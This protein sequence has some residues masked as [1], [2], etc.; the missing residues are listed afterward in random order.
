[1]GG[2]AMG[3]AVS[4]GPSAR[5]LALADVTKDQNLDLLV[6]NSTNSTVSFRPGN[7]NGTFGAGA[8]I[9]VGIDPYAVVVGDVNGDQSPDFLFT[10]SGA[11]KVGVMLGNGAGTFNAAAGSPFAVGTFPA[12]MSI[13]DL[14]GDGQLDFATANQSSAN[15]S[16]LSGNGAGVFAAFPVSPLAGGN[17]PTGIATGDF[18][19]DGLVD[20]AN[21]NFFGNTAAV[22]LAICN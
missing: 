15:L 12:F 5:Y 3:T 10:S 13:A 19:G 21:T 1:M 20:L 7:G 14:N 6:P 2:L 17:G 22:R 18:N 11:N 9:A 4:V 8:N 16:L